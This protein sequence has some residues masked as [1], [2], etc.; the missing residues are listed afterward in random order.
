MHG[1]FCRTGSYNEIFKNHHIAHGTIT[2]AEFHVVGFFCLQ[3]WRKFQ[4]V[5]K[6]RNLHL[7]VVAFKHMR[8]LSH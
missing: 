7:L 3:L 2:V 5:K 6:C 4:L 8:K 1:T